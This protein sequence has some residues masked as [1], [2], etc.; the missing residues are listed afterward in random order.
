V[1]TPWARAALP[2]RVARR[3][4]SGGAADPDLRRSP[5]DGDRGEL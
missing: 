3:T 4:S 5:V 1:S 2:G